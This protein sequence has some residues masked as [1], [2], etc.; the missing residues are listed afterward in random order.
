MQA[1]Q[2]MLLKIFYHKEQ[3]NSLN[4]FLTYFLVNLR[5]RQPTVS[6]D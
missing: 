6:I 3:P 4:Y 5:F 1:K 2:Y